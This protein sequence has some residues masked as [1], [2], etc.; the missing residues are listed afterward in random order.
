MEKYKTYINLFVPP[1]IFKK[2]FT[3]KRYLLTDVSKTKR[4][5]NF[6]TKSLEEFINY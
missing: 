5:I 1:K 6:P 3:P 4:K 2:T